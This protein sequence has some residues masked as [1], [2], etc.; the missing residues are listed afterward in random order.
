MSESVWKEEVD[1]GL[2]NYIRSIVSLRKDGI[3]YQ[4]PVVVRKPDEDFKEEQY[5]LISIYNLYDTFSTVRYSP[6]RVRISYN[7]TNKNAI[8]EDS[9][10]PYDLSYQIDFWA[11][12]QSEMN[13]MTRLWLANNPKYFNLPVKDASGN[14]RS[15]LALQKGSVKK[16]DI[17][18]GQE[19]TFHS[20]ITY[21]IS[22]SLDENIKTIV[23]IVTDIQLRTSMLNK[24]E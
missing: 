22:V 20:I 12:L 16:E 8:L 21:R 2:I 15:C 10:I 18:K 24:E 13:E 6:E 11:K 1:T 23:P 7:E 5:P 9:A 17:L 3:I 4:V 14:N 19:R